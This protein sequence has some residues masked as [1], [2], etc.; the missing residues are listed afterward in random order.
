[1]TGAR[2]LEGRN[3]TNEDVGIASQLAA[4]ALHELAEPIARLRLMQTEPSL[5]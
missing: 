3:L 1:M 5:R 4:E 2:G